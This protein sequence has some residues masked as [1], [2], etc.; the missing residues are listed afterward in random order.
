MIQTEFE[1]TLP[2]GYRSKDGTLHTKGVMR[3]SNAKDEIAPLTDPR[4]KQNPAYLIIILL[5]RVI[6][7]L[8]D[9]PAI[10]TSIIESL[11]AA[12]LRYLQDFYQQINVYATSWAKGVC[13]HCEKEFEMDLSRLGE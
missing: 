12:D 1:F 13:P 9:L 8:G 2:V 3:L 6:I 5:A 11:Y 7:K 10:N 4:V